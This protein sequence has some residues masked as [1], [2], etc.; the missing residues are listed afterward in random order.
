[1]RRMII[2]FH[3]HSHASDGSLSPS[4]LLGRARSAGVAALALTDHDTVAGYV[5]LKQDATAWDDITLLSGAELS[6]NWGK[7]GVH[8][9][10]LGMDV[11]HP[12]FVRGMH[13]LS[14][15]RMQRAEIIG[16]RLE[17]AGMSGA[18]AGA[19]ALAGSSQLGRP[20]FASWMHAQG[21]V[22]DLSQAYGRYLGSGKMG[23]VKT[24]WPEL[25]EA[26][27]WIR[28]SGG[29]A[30]LAH[31]LNYKMTRTKLRA[32]VSDFVAAGGQAIEVFSGRQSGEQVR[33]LCKLAL[34][35]GLA[36]SAGSDFHGDRDY[37]PRLGFDTELLPKDATLVNVV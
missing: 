10:G 11:D 30:V 31:P 14:T 22:R 3:T 8:V 34:D 26:V 20:H 32:C 2:D 23:D 4:E 13:Q 15:A 25:A 5:D 12:V 9:V 6:C 17:K 19:Q 1:M 36:V 29:Q 35:S 28:E 16:E 27:A 18:L 24:L 37:G 21:H 33:D 7:V